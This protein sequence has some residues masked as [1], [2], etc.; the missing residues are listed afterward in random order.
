MGY[1]LF[2][3]GFILMALMII[4]D[5]IESHKDLIIMTKMTHAF[6]VSIAF[7]IVG[8]GIKIFQKKE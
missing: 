5:A 8:I 7:M 1:V 3:L 2:W 4:A 6:L